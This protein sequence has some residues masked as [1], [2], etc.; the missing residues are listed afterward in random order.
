M[1][2]VRDHFDPH[3]D[4]VMIP[5]VPLDT[6]D[7]T[8]YTMNLG[9]K[10]ILD[11]TRK[12]RAQEFV[13]PVAAEV[14]ARVAKLKGIDARILDLHLMHDTLLLVKVRGLGMPVVEKLVRHTELPGVRMVAAVS[15]DVNIRDRESAIWGVFTRFD[16]ERDILF[17]EQK[18]IGISPVYKGIMGIDAT[19]KQGYPKPLTMPDEVRKK[20]EE[21]WDS[22][23]R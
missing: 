4:F 21:R 3:F 16:C 1:R 20:V 9:S 13:P 8:S 2:Q 18:L 17:T 23:W 19:W 15:E 6:L 14:E 22:Y 11:A 5:R 12:A 7:F 10:M